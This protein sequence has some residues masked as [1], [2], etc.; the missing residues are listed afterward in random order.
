MD[1]CSFAWESLS[2]FTESQ[3]FF[4]SQVEETDAEHFD[5]I[6]VRQEM[7]KTKNDLK[8][9]ISRYGR[10]V[11]VNSFLQFHKDRL[12]TCFITEKYGKK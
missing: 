9:L 5:Q 6:A 3:L 11:Q 2:I 8:Y 7:G 12:S 4:F 1:F 10:I